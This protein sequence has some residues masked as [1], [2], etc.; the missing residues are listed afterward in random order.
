[1]SYKLQL[2]LIALLEL[3]VIVLALVFW[4]SIAS[5]M[6]VF[7]AILVPCATLVKRFIVDRDSS[8]YDDYN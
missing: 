1:M 4:G 5:V 6:F 8:D 7:L 2:L 3:V